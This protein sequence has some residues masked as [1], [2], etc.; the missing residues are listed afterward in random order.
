MRRHTQTDVIKLAEHLGLGV[1]RQSPGDGATRY[2]FY[3]LA[4]SPGNEYS[5]RPCGAGN[6]WAF[7]MGFLYASELKAKLTGEDK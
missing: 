7:L 5:Y 3:P 2:G 1:V 6:A 4:G